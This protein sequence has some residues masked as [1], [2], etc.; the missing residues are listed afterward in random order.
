[1]KAK[2]GAWLALGRALMGHSGSSG[3]GVFALLWAVPGM[4]WARARGR[5]RGLST[6]NF[7]A[8]LVGIGYIISPVDFV[9]ELFFNA[10]GLTDDAVVAAWL[11][12]TL[13]SEADT[14]LLAQADAA[15]Q[16]T[17]IVGESV[18]ADEPHRR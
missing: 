16:P 2:R 17:V 13:L 5:Y 10:L 6:A 14:Y 18:P 11:A 9:P 4:L 15:A 7:V 12:G 1:M 8:I 3:R